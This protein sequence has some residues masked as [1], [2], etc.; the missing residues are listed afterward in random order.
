MKFAHTFNET[1]S[2]ENFP[3]EW[4]AAAI[5]YRQLKKCI[6]RVKQELDALGLNV[7]T[8]KELI[9]ECGDGGTAGGPTLQYMFDGRRPQLLEEFG[10]P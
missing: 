9:S 2:S 5:Q 3:P 7:N 1:L 8:L 10:C 6:K 4:Q